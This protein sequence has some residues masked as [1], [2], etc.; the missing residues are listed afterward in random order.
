MSNFFPTQ[1]VGR[2]YPQLFNQSLMNGNSILPS[3]LDGPSFI[4]ELDIYSNRSLTV[5]KLISDTNMTGST[6]QGNDPINLPEANGYIQQH[7][8]VNVLKRETWDT[9]VGQLVF[10]LRGGLQVDGKNRKHAQYYWLSWGALNVYLR[11]DVGRLK[12]GRDINTFNLLK[13]WT[14]AGQQQ[15]PPR[16]HKRGFNAQIE[17]IRIAKRM[18]TC[19]Y[20]AVNYQNENGNTYN[21]LRRLDKLFGTFRRYHID[22][23]DDYT[24]K[25]KPVDWT[26]NMNSNV[27]YHNPVVNKAA[28]NRRKLPPPVQS[29]EIEPSNIL[30]KLPYCYQLPREDYNDANYQEIPNFYWR[31]DPEHTHVNKPG[32]LDWVD[33][34]DKRFYIGSPIYI[35]YLQEEINPS[36]ADLT[37]NMKTTAINCTYPIEKDIRMYEAAN[38]MHQIEIFGGI[39]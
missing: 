13:D 8:H 7:F 16:A 14:F 11:S 2:R 19:L 21:G 4:G 36:A 1:D 37:G 33:F 25:Y 29:T 30:Y 18:V 28:A 26:L 17:V 35:G 12:Y 5:D 24:P 20:W 6:F 10:L 39:F 27:D 15:T 38:E 22:D 23:I 3:N 32:M 34:S 9:N 31:L